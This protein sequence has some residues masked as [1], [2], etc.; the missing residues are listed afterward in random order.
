[1]KFIFR[2]LLLGTVLTVFNGTS[3]F[4]QTDEALLRDLAEE[5]KK[6][7]EAL[8]LYPSETRM[9][10]LEA[11]KYPEILIKMQDLREKTSAAFRTL[12]EDFPRTT[13]AFFYDI[14]RYSGLTETLVQAKNDPATIRK[15]LEALPEN[16]RSEAFGIVD[17]QMPTLVQ[18]NTLNQTTQRTFERLIAG[19]P[20]PAQGAFEHLLGLPE[21]IDLLNEDLRFTLI[22]GETYKENPVRVIQQMDSLNLVVARSHAEELDNWKTTIEN[23]PEAKA[24]LQSAAKEYAKENGY[25]AED[26]YSDDLYNDRNDYDRDEEI[27]VHHYYHPFS[28]WYGYP[29]WEPFPRWRPYPWWWDWGYNYQPYG[30]VIVYLPSYY[31]M[32][33]YFEHPNHHYHYNRLSTHFVEHYNGHRHSGTSV[34]MGV[35]D[36][37]QRNGTIISEEFL[38]DKK[39]LSGNLKEYGRFEQGRRDY[40]TKNP[41]NT[42]T[43]EVYLERNKQKYP[44]IDRSRTAAKSDLQRADEVKR[45]K[46]SDWAPPKAKTQP[47]PAPAP[48]TERPARQQP[49]PMQPPAKTEPPAKRETVP[50]RPPRTRPEEAREYNRQKWEE[51]KP[52][53]KPPQETRRSNPPAPAPKQQTAKPQQVTPRS[54]PAPAPNKEAPKSTKSRGAG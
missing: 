35:H 44:D 12:I 51:I 23:D 6:S 41:R 31:C 26:Y 49:P 17:R 36:W 16:K 8:V 20:A 18:I 30:V 43:P 39:H 46:R 47:E 34:S 48:K 28:Y 2:L 22:V 42:V 52:A 33:W 4:A 5:N 45:A 3:V 37:H 24:E 25:G 10:I 11:T 40:N 38:G 53:P 27:I 1:M 19:Y 21:V 54:K 14:N 7:V 9:A 13:Q 32:N 29:Y 15:A 50:T